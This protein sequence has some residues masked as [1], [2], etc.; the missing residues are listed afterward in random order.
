[1]NEAYYIDVFV[2]KV[3]KVIKAEWLKLDRLIIKTLHTLCINLIIQ[4]TVIPYCNWQRR[5]EDS[6]HYYL[7]IIDVIDW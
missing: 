6:Y 1:M 3:V 7:P 5:M 4:Q 2:V